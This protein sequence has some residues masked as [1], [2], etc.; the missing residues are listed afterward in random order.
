MSMFDDDKN[1]TLEPQDVE[2]LVHFLVFE[3]GEDRLTFVS[4]PVSNVLFIMDIIMG[5]FA[6]LLHLP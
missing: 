1:G 2:R 4:Q 3:Y 5:W 6:F